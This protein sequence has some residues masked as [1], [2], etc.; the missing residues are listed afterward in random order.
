LQKIKAGRILQYKGILSATVCRMTRAHWVYRTGDDVLCYFARDGCS[1]VKRGL[2]V[3]V[4][5]NMAV[6]FKSVICKEWRFPTTAE[7]VRTVLCFD[8]FIRF[9][10]VIHLYQ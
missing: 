6:A 5:D 9:I 4:I 7:N 2:E 10:K 1:L 8:S 3:N